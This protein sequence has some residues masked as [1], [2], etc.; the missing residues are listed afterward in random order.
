MWSVP[1]LHVHSSIDYELVKL[2]HPDSPQCRNLPDRTRHARF[3]AITHAYDI[4]KGR[5]GLYGRDP[6]REELERRRRSMARR[7]RPRTDVPHARPADFDWNSSADDRWKDWVIIAVGVLVS[8]LLVLWWYLIPW[9]DI[10][11]T[12]AIGL[13]PAVWLPAAHYEKTHLAAAENLA[14]ARAEAREFGEER[15][16]EIRRRVEEMRENKSDVRLA[17]SSVKPTLPN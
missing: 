5:H 9:I 16:R 11:Q 7:Q 12:L 3:Q 2:H 15:R 1:M 17:C 8:P 14:R 4:L 6:A 10:P 13:F